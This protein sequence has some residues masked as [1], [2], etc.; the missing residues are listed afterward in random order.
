MT[1][2]PRDER[3]LTVLVASPSDLDPERNRLEEVIRELNLTWSKTFHLRLDLVLW[4]THGYPGLGADAQDV[5]NR[6]LPDPDIFIGLMWARYG[7]PTGRAG[8]GT[9]EEFS[10]ALS[11]YRQDPTS[12]R[13]MIY[14]KDAPLSPSTIEPEQLAK[15]QR[16]RESLGSEGALHWRFG[17]LEE[18]ERLLRL[19]LARQI[20]E[21]VAGAA[22]P[23]PPPGP[24]GPNA[25]EEELGLLD[26][27]DLVEENFGALAEVM[28]RITAETTTL[29]QKMEQRAQEV[30]AAAAKA[31]GGLPPREARVL[32]ER[33]ASD[34]R[35]FV[36][37]MNA[38]TPLFRELL[39]RGADA[40]TR[41]ALLSAGMASEDKRQVREARAVLAAFCDAL[42]GA[43]TG[44]ESFRNT[45][46]G[47][48]RM[49]VLLN[50]AKRET[51]AALQDILGSLAEGRR[52]VTETVRALDALLG[53]GT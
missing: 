26:F 40:A 4:E 16:F 23:P 47:L 18:F 5:L 30:T 42:G 45:I 9:E 36:A 53:E 10:R 37:R 38:E 13:V 1:V 35:Q 3:V 24:A 34:M 7:T 20:Q 17:T 50:K 43:Y 27:L 52:I 32:S 48:P 28:G 12:V 11:R 19:H 14:F 15:V 49:T 2:M 8:S 46:Q 29:G 39:R 33:T 6:E 25:E 44:A 31:P 51:A 21:E 41:A 22:I